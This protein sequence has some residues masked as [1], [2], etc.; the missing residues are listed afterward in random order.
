[1]CSVLAES[2]PPVLK[3]AP[4][5]SASDVTMRSFPI[6]FKKNGP[7]LT[8]KMRLGLKRALARFVPSRSSPAAIPVSARVFARIGTLRYDGGPGRRRLVPCVVQLRMP[9]VKH[10][11]ASRTG[12]CPQSA[13]L[14]SNPRLS[15]L[16]DTHTHMHTHN[17]RHSKHTQEHTGTHKHAQA[18][19]SIHAAG[20]NSCWPFCDRGRPSQWACMPK[21]PN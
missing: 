9:G 19:A 4:V 20:R 5:C 18:F 17:H 3:W 6:L 11:G 14:G 10:A 2:Q 15:F 12:L 13:A 8:K 16:S 7:G 1:M 21:A